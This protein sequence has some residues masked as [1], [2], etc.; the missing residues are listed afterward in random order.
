M[1]QYSY[2]CQYCLARGLTSDFFGEFAVVFKFFMSFD[3]SLSTG[4]IYHHLHG[5][6]I[7]VERGISA[8]HAILLSFSFNWIYHHLCGN[9]IEVERGICPSRQF[10]IALHRGQKET[11][12]PLSIFRFWIHEPNLS[13][14]AHITLIITLISVELLFKLSFDCLF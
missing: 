5:E 7:E 12:F 6:I 3:L 8:L 1:H 2:K 4:Y 13:Y 14:H 10:A 11:P 9:I